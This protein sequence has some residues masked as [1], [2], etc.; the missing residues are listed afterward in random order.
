MQ[1]FFAFL[2]PVLALSLVFAACSSSDDSA[3]DDPTPAATSPSDDGGN[4]GNGGDGGDGGGDDGD[5]TDGGNG[6]D[7]SNGDS[8]NGD[9]EGGGGDDDGDGGS[10]DGGNGDDDGDSGDGGSDNDAPSGLSILSQTAQNLTDTRYRVVYQLTSMDPGEDDIS[11]TFTIASDPPRSS[12]MLDGN[13]AGEDTTLLVIMDE[14]VTYF[15]GDL[16]DGSQCLEL[17]S[18]GSAPFSLPGFFD[19][20]V[21]LDGV[22]SADG[23]TIT[24]LPGATYA[25]ISADCYGVDSPDGEGIICVG[26]DEGQLLF[27]DIDGADGADFQIEA[28]EVGEP[29]DAD[30]EPPFPVI[31]F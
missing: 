14:E 18:G 2:V 25:G 22:I 24:S 6:G 1:R 30:F 7:G 19:T 15:C 29:S 5:G 26:S 12:F 31:S 17:P 9:D 4:G 8:G 21:V 13:F 16:G 27:L 20:D 28:L 10:G 11:G 3:A 23:V